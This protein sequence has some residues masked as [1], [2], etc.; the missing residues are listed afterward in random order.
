MPYEHPF[1]LQFRNDNNIN[2]KYTI[3]ISHLC[4]FLKIM[5]ALFLSF[6][7]FTKTITNCKNEL[8][9]RIGLIIYA[10]FDNIT[11]LARNNA[12][13][14]YFETRLFFENFLLDSK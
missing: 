7:P 8:N 3:R 13:A 2:T 5:N 9:H 11:V 10:I 14:R 6:Q 4:R 12:H 1:Q